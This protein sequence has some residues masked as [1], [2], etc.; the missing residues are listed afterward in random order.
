[1]VVL[2]VLTKGHPHVEDVLRVPVVPV[3]RTEHEL[4]VLL[5]VVSVVDV[6]GAE[7]SVITVLVVD[8]HCLYLFFLGL[9]S[10]VRWRR[11]KHVSF[12]A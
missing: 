6:V 7:E 1:M 2:E 10:L 9:V 11:A 5:L 8:T 4:M 12:A 3:R